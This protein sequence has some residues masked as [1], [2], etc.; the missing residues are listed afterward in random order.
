MKCPK[1][2]ADNFYVGLIS[3]GECEN[4]NCEL[5][6][7]H[8]KL[9]HAAIDCC[10]ELRDRL[11]APPKKKVFYFDLS[12]IPADRSLLH[13]SNFEKDTT[14]SRAFKST[15]FS[16]AELYVDVFSE[17]LNPPKVFLFPEAEVNFL[18]VEMHLDFKKSETAE[19][20]EAADALDISE[21]VVLL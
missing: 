6:P 12:K 8:I 20:K 1:C 9:T 16:A 2:N 14:F 19:T 11:I 3:S 5:N 17:I 4:P 10:V 13:N 7:N 18:N 21:D 15:D